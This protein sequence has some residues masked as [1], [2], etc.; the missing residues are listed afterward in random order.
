MKKALFPLLLC[1]AVL[2][3][4][5][6]AEASVPE[7]VSVAGQEASAPETGSQQ[8]SPDAATAS[9]PEEEY[10]EDTS[11]MFS[12]RDFRSSYDPAESISIT[13][14]GD[15][16][17]C[18]SDAVAISGSTVTIQAE[19][20]FVLSGTL[21]DG[22]VI[23]DVTKNDKVQLV[24]DGADIHSETSAP[25]YVRKADKVFITLP[26]GSENTLSCGESYTPI[27]DNNIDAAIFAK[28]DLTLN[29]S[30]K[31]TITAPGGHGIEAKDSLAITGGNYTI[32]AASHALSAND[33]ICIAEGTFALTAG[34]DGIH[35]KN[36]DDPTLGFVYIKGGLF[37]I[38]AAGDGISGE[39]Y[40]EI[41]DGTFEIVSG[42]GS[43]NA[44]AHQGG[45]FP[46]GPPGSSGETT[47]E[48]STSTKGIKATGN[49]TISGGTFTIDAEDDGI[50]S[51]ASVTITGGTFDIASGDDGVHADEDLNVEEGVI[52]VSTSYEGLEGLNITISGG[53]ISLVSTDDGINAAGGSMED[54]F[55][56]GLSSEPTLEF[57]TATADTAVLTTLSDGFPGG[58]P[59]GG[60]PGG[61]PGGGFGGPP[62]GPG[63]MGGNASL[64]ITGGIITINASGD[65]IDANG[66]IEITGGTV[67]INGPTWGDTSILDYDNTAT[68]SGDAVFIGTGSTMMAQY[69]G[70]SEHG[71]LFLRT[72]NQAAESTLIVSDSE[73]NEIIS[74][75]PV[76]DYALLICSCPGLVKGETY[77]VTIGETVLETEAF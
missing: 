76:N 34:K 14:S 41:L 30:G 42:V 35:A 75:T 54:Y 62:G 64:L 33:D 9:V 15:T 47:D 49:V 22:M 36:N 56:G 38:T 8:E 24:L 43:A 18:D 69:F 2:F 65:N 58:G 3:S 29:G 10:V 52:G 50:H 51:N 48:E 27:D 74:V 17:S 57:T 12:Q 60:G 20:T 31:L 53:Q 46:F 32:T 39:G 7:A 37:Q 11:G 28:D 68:I 63:M 77:I 19:G 40:V 23:V 67:I 71:Q 66:T 25:I 16:A 21:D 4:G 45:G 59:G 55:G 70:E 72:G 13:L 73:G 6:G 1:L 26:E 44:P 5:C 61:R